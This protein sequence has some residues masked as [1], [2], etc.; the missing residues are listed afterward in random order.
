[1]LRK[2]RDMTKAP[3]MI[4]WKD[5][6]VPVRFSVGIAVSFAANA[7]YDALYRS[8]DSALYQAKQNGKGGYVINHPD[9]EKSL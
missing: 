9:K 6:V 2:A 4:E 1:M 8:A 7:D 5:T 3:L